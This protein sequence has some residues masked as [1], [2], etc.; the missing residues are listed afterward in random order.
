MEYILYKKSD[1]AVLEKAFNE[2]WR[3]MRAGVPPSD[4]EVHLRLLVLS[5]SSDNVSAGVSFFGTVTVVHH[6]FSVL[7]VVFVC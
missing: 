7:F 1:T 3:L 4:V 5:C 6:F 2:G